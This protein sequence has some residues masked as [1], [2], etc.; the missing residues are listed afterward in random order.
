MKKRNANKMKESRKKENE[1]VFPSSHL[2][3][4]YSNKKAEEKIKVESSLKGKGVTVY[5]ELF[6]CYSFSLENAL[7]TSRVS[8]LPNYLIEQLSGLTGY[9][10]W[11]SG[12]LAYKGNNWRTAAI[13]GC[14][15]S[16]MEN[17]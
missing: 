12:D 9:N 16:F 2:L 6:Q 13:E 11:G 17:H 14:K 10:Q 4:D 5:N 15:F 1:K 8:R 3:L 7:L